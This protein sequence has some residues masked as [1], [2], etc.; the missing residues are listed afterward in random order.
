MA[1]QKPLPADEAHRIE[2][3]RKQATETLA[4]GELDKARAEFEQILKTL[5]YDASA[6]RDAARAAEAAGKFE[7][8]AEALEKAHHFG[9]H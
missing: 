5:P 6:E 4:R 3:L 9:G 2:E 1:G 8:A 7:Y